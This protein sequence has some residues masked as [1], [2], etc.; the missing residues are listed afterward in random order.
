MINLFLIK[1]KLRNRQTTQNTNN[2]IL[3]KYKKIA[4]KS[5]DE[6][7]KEFTTDESRGLND[8][9]VE[10]RLNED[11]DNIVVKEEKHSWFYFF[12]NSFKDKFIL[13]LVILAGITNI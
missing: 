10:Q 7:L 13:I 11:G 2:E 8:K 6:I 9:I 3:E 12:V 5:K 1:N 4:Q